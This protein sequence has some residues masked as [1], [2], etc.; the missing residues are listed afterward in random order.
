MKFRPYNHSR[1]HDWL[2]YDGM[3][4]ALDAFAHRTLRDHPE[5]SNKEFERV[6][7]EVV[8]SLTVSDSCERCIRAHI[9]YKP[10][11]PVMTVRD[12]EGGVCGHYRCDRGHVWKCWHASRR[13]YP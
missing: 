9:K 10:Y 3:M 4:R 8:R 5:L 13:D 7:L 11:T 2:E 1:Y 6:V 12:S